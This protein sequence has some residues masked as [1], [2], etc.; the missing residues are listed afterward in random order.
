MVKETL[1][2]YPIKSKQSNNKVAITTK[3][4]DAPKVMGPINS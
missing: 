1:T 3:T 4:M 2:F